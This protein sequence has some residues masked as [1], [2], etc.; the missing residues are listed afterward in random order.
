[1]IVRKRLDGRRKIDVAVAIG[2]KCTIESRLTCSGSG[3]GDLQT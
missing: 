3:G 2:V 1:M